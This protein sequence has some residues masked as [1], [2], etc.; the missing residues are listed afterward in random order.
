MKTLYVGN[1]PQNSN[2]NDL[3]QMFADYGQVHSVTLIVDR[4]TG[5]Q[6][7]FGFIDMDDLAANAAV[8]TLNKKQFGG[9]TLTVDEASGR[10]WHPPIRPRYD[11]T[12]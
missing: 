10:T 12:G 5:K 6:R 7:G 9:R 2:I 8:K 1:L 11:T 3:R 4:N